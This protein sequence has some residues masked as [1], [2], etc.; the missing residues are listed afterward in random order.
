MNLSDTIAAIATAKGVG[1]ISIVRVSGQKALDIALKITKKKYLEPRVAT[2]CSLYNNKD[3]LLDLAIVIFFKAPKSFTGEDIVEFQTHGGVVVADLVLETALDFGARLAEPGEFLKRAYLNNKIDLSQVE[4][5]SRLIEARSTD[6]IKAIAKN[7]KGE[8]SKLIEEIRK[9]L[10]EVLAYIEVSIDYAEEDLPLDLL[11]NIKNKVSEVLKLLSQMYEASKSRY[12]I[13]DGFKLAIIGK[14]N[15]GKSSLLNRLLKYERAIVSDIAGTT[16]DTIEESIKIGTHIVKIIDTAG[17]REAKDE[18]EKIGIERSKIALVESDT[19]LCLFDS[20]K[21]LEKEDFEILELIKPFKETKN[22][23]AILNK[24]DLPK[25]I[26]DSKIDIQKKVSIS[27]KN[28]ISPLILELTEIL[29]KSCDYEG[30]LLGSKRSIEF[31]RVAIAYLKSAIERL[32]TK[33]FELFSFD[34]KE[35]LKEISKL[36][37]PFEYSE[38][39]D[40]IFSEFCLGK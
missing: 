3:E 26:D 32:E 18:I 8:L 19:I 28:D 36:T 35:A 30:V 5:I 34:I 20:S 10:L 25:K 27:C 24:S 31:V 17:I 2:L 9:K 12:G 33:E 23:I 29:D 13:F 16:R 1:G 4:A 38:L 37:R 7:L 15:S 14:P 22:F 39:L 11:D 40:T 21:E 6:A